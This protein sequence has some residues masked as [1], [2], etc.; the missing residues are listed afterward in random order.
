MARVQRDEKADELLLRNRPS[1]SDSG[2]E[3]DKVE[4]L[5]ISKIDGDEVEVT[6]RP[7]SS[8]P[9]VVMRTVAEIEAAMIAARNSEEMMATGSESRCSSSQTA[10]LSLDTE[11]GTWDQF[12]RNYQW[13][14][15]TSTYSE[16]L[17]TTKLDPSKVPEQKRKDAE[18]IA[19]EIEEGPNFSQLEEGP[20]GS[21]LDEEARFSAVG[22]NCEQTPESRED[23]VAL[24]QARPW[25]RGRPWL[26]LAFLA[27]ILIF[28]IFVIILIFATT[29][30][31]SPKASAG[32]GAV[33][34]AVATHSGTVKSG[35]TKS[36]Q[37]E[38]FRLF[39]VLTVKLDRPKEV[40]GKVMSLV[41]EGARAAAE[42][43]APS[44]VEKPP[45]S[46]TKKAAPSA[47]ILLGQMRQAKFFALQRTEANQATKS[48]Q[49]ESRRKESKDPQP[50]NPERNP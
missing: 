18:R 11:T 8:E 4:G 29:A 33:P 47:L 19:R 37:S 16:D 32:V 39:E 12:E 48:R 5:R 41:A 44:T 35:K 42:S 30:D 22:R 14:G 25:C 36:T 17:Y 9:K 23:A 28:V 20:E 45:Q 49:V 1:S 21:D 3:G 15:V 26:A 13:F 50:L 6:T 31:H 2:K 24:E 7:V 10:E 43:V 40:S 34:Q 27:I 46:P 38:E